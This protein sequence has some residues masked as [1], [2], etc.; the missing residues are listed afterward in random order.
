MS[1]SKHFKGV[2]YD[3]IHHAESG[4]SYLHPHLGEACEEVKINEVTIDLLARDSYPESLPI[5][6]PL[7]LALNALHEKM[8]EIV[9]KKNLP[10]SSIVRFDLL[11]KFD[12]NRS[13]NYLCQIKSELELNNG[14]V[15]VKTI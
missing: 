12:P 6:Q 9:E 3:V 11:F 7:K 15:Y 1:S 2:A 4:L 8:K 5:K 10:F 13:D 14:K